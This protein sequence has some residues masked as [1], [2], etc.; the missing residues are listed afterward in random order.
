MMKI[1][2]F[3]YQ[4][5]IAFAIYKVVCSFNLIIWKQFSKRRFNL[6]QEPKEEEKKN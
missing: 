5:R 2:F 3:A 6:T 1:S 4:G